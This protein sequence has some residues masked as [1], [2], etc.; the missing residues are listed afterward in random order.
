MKQG[1]LLGYACVPEDKIVDKFETL[2]K[3]IVGG[4][5]D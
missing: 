5:K 3:S 4:L 1:L 2:L